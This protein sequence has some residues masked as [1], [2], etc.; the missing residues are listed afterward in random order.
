MVRPSKKKSSSLSR[1]TAQREPY[2]LVLI[3]CE[4][5]KTEPNYLESLRDAENLSSVNIVVSGNGGS[6]PMSVVND[7]IRLYKERAEEKNASTLYD[8]VYCLIDRDKHDKFE[9]AVQKAQTFKHGKKSNIIRLVR[10]FPSFEYWYLCHFVYTRASIS[11]K[12]KKSAGDVCCEQLN[13]HWQKHFKKKY[14]KSEARIYHTLIDRLDTAL[15]NAQR[16]HKDALSTAEM[17]PSTEMHIL[18]DYLRQIKSQ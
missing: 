10:S 13:V 6:D 11:A 2:E 17:N 15:N 1:R 5:S 12:G 8:R 7:A 9:D 3:V 18:V 16:A 14:G 4:G